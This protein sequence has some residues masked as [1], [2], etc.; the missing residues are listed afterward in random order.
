M[1]AFT[2]PGQGSR[3]PAM[4]SP[5]VEHPSWELVDEASDV[6]GRDVARLLLSAEGDELQGSRNT[7]LAT[8]VAS[9]VVLDA[10][11]RVGLVPAICA[12][13]G[14]GEY[15]ALTATGAL[16][17]PDGVRVVTALGDALQEAAHER[18]GTMAAVLGLDDED[19]DVAC[20]RADGEVW[21]ANFN[22]PG[23]VVVAGTAESVGA[24]TDAARELGAKRVRPLGVTGA[25]HTPLM[26]SARDQV[27]K[28][29]DEAGLRDPDV[30][31]VANV[32]AR[33]HVAAD[34]W[35]SLL[36]A[37]LCSPVRWRQSVQR[38]ADD[39]VSTFLE[40]GGG[41]ALT[42]F[43][44][45]NA[46]RA[47]AWSIAT[48]DDLDQLLEAMEG[49]A[50]TPDGP[51]DHLEGE[52]LHVTERLVVSPAA[53]VFVPDC[54]WRTR[55]TTAGGAAVEVGELLGR[56]GDAEVRS[57]FAGTVMGL[58]AL[59]GE[60]VTASQPIAWLRASA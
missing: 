12:G 16:S 7:V 45:R 25:L 54:R 8:F 35:G 52:H 43:A 53:G 34:E 21:I 3:P 15:T 13:H 6:A 59:E 39:G 18:P 31:V 50:A 24:A 30:G 1:L 5:W 28:A 49:G 58:V 60:R 33:P 36:S 22:A 51:H 11:E 42:G 14:V 26:I 23:Q 9:L 44:R 27:R 55:S 57:R 19:A 56:V 46:P 4:G 41:G 20:R 48:P 37:Q 32:D 38:M 40:L 17:F 2:F 47:R 10:V 29:V